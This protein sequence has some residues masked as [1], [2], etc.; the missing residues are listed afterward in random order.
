MKNKHL[1][2]IAGPT[3][4]GKTALAI[5]VAQHYNTEI[6]SADSRQFYK[7]LNIG[8]AR[9]SKE[10]LEA[11]QHHF[12]CSHS[13]KEPLSAGRFANQAH[14][15]IQ[16]LFSHKDY[17]VVVGGS[18]LFIDAIIKGL[19]D[20]PSD[21]S[22]KRE[23]ELEWNN[24]GLEHLQNKLAALDPEYFHSMDQNNPHRLIRAI[25]VCLLTKQ[26]Y[27]DLRKGKEEALPYAVDL[28]VLNTDRNYL[29]ERI[30]KRVDIMMEE[31]LEEEAR[32]LYHLKELVAL[33]TVGYKELFEYFDGLCTKEIAIAKIKQHSRNYAK[34][35]IT[36]WKRDQS[37]I[38]IDPLLPTSLL[39]QLISNIKN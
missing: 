36:W 19:D 37:A 30:N 32:S 9:P 13:I 4:I 14:E 3:G 15:K 17:V 1:I 11:V 38:W 24:Q 10:E 12:V 20:L 7:E 28:F 33:N 16:Q 31:G 26:K 29:Y 2:V 5:E 8:V 34:R 27:S 22:L 18:G 21:T 23:L 39:S 6:I 25:E 35:Q